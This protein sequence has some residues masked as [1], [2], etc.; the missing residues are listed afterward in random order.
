MARLKRAERDE[1]ERRKTRGF[2]VCRRKAVIK[3]DEHLQG[4]GVLLRS[5]GLE[6]TSEGGSAIDD[7]DH[8]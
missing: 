1:P 4:G 8:D 2:D 5:Q 7:R 3:R 6:T